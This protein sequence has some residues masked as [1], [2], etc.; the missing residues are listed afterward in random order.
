[1]SPEEGTPPLPQLD[2]EIQDFCGHT[3]HPPCL[4]GF[5]SSSQHQHT[6]THTQTNTPRHT[7]IPF[8]HIPH[9]QTLPIK[10]TSSIIAWQPLYERLLICPPR[11]LLKHSWIALF[12]SS[13]KNGQKDGEGYV[14]I[15]HFSQVQQQIVLI[16]TE[17]YKPQA[18]H[19]FVVR[20]YHQTEQ[21]FGKHNVGIGVL[22]LYTWC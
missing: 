16:C 9:T 22:Q 12:Y 6:L 19:R 8:Q 13:G 20:A 1:M 11:L 14:H 3:I 2:T 17:P 15:L 10:V 7:A 21:Y 4:S 5:K 18:N